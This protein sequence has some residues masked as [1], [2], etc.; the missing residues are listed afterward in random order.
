VWCVALAFRIQG[1]EFSD[2]NHIEISR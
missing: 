2:I 1:V